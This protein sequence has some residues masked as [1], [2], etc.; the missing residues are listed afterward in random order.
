MGIPW[1]S[2]ALLLLDEVEKT[3]EVVPDAYML[4]TVAVACGVEGKVDAVKKVFEKF[5]YYRLKPDKV[6][7]R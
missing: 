6:R 1:D 3:A 7:T 2:Q 5:A 4:G